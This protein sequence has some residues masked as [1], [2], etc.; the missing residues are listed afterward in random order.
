MGVRLQQ[1]SMTLNDLER[2]RNGRLLSFSITHYLSII[3]AFLNI[4]FT[5]IVYCVICQLSKCMFDTC[6]IEKSISQTVL[7]CLVGQSV[8][9]NR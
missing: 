1:M 5:S 4:Y 9:L 7:S 8:S 2:Q 6:Y 3:F